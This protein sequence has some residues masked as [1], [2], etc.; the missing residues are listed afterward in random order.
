V[1]TYHAIALVDL[2]DTLF[3]TA[4]KCPADIPFEHLTLMAWGDDGRPI[5]YATPRQMNF[6]RWLEET[7]LVVAVTARSTAAL[8]RTGLKFEKAVTA[9]GA[10]ILD[11][12]P[13][14]HAG[15]PNVRRA[16]W[17]STMEKALASFHKDLL[18]LERDVLG[19]AAASNL[20]V[21]TNIIKEDGLPLYL[22]IK[23]QDPD[24]NDAELHRATAPA[25]NGLPHEWTA[26]VNG[27]NVAL[28]PPGLGK[29]HA[30]R[31]LLT[32][33][34]AQYPHL[35]VIGIGDSHT[36]ADFMAQCDF[37]MTPTASQLA[38]R[39]FAGLTAKAPADYEPTQ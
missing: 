16:A 28:L 19:N 27:N 20:R 18:E 26:H 1:S 7:S 34:R 36:D 32:E 24:G 9:H 21:R 37:A 10:V 22:V 2:D 3:Q 25:L 12:H 13:K 29:A 6:I 39:L 15:I 38:T 30:V 17:Q 31:D 5:S 4:R 35:P 11:A 23:H 33:L 14:E 8:I